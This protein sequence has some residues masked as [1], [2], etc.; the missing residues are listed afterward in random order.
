VIGWVGELH[1]RWQQKYELPEPPVL[2]ELDVET[3]TGI[4]M[5]Q[6]REISKFPP[7]IR[8]RAV[9]VDETLPASA[10]LEEM[11]RFR[12]AVVQDI[13]LFD[14]YRGGGLGRGKKSLAFRI[15]MQDTSKTLTDAEGDAAMAQLTELL[16][17]KFGAKLRT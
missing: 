2:F 3:L 16:A 6:Y 7:V 1:P 5:P 9:V 13:R 12:P 10:L 15:V 4:D 17:S 14:V 11:R 8:D